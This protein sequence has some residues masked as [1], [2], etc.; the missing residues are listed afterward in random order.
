MLNEL[1]GL[2]IPQVGTSIKVPHDG[3]STSNALSIKNTSDGVL[4]HC[5]KCGYSM[6]YKHDDQS[7]KAN[8]ERRESEARAIKA[9][10][11]KD[12]FTLPSDFTHDI[13]HPGIAWLAK[14]GWSEKLILN[15]G[16][17][18]SE[19]LNRVVIP[20]KPSGY[21]A[22]AVNPGQYP[23]YL[24]KAPQGYVWKSSSVTNMV[25]CVTEDIMSAG[26]VGAFM[27]AQALLG[28]PTKWTPEEHVKRLVIWLDNDAAGKKARKA[29]TGT[30]N[31]LGIH[32]I[33]IE[34][35]KDPKLYSDRDIAHIL[36]TE[37][38]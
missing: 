34:T 24:T 9:E 32:A 7:W 16:I 26:R 17:G 11:D 20:L 8:K 15:H 12:G 13:P 19:S 37:C 6:L 2:P 23:K 14:C 29:I 38:K 10:R 4:V 36:R 28:T 35:A 25:L 30:C 27:N 33:N 1:Q 21:Q 5:F 3:C 22:R 31:W 18:W